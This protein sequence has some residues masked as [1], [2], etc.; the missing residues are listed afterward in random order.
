[1]H[2]VIRMTLVGSPDDP[3]SFQGGV[4]NTLR[5]LKLEP[6]RRA[7]AIVSIS[8]ALT[9]SC[10]SAGLD[11][12]AVIL[13]PN[14]VDLELFHPLNGSE[15]RNLRRA[16]GLNPDPRYIVFVGRCSFRKGIDILV[17]AFIQVARRH[18]DV[19]TLIIGPVD[20][21]HIIG[22]H[23]KRQNLLDNLKLELDRTGYS[24]RVHWVGTVENAHQYLQAA[25][26]F[27]LP[28]RRE[29]LPNAIVEAMAVGLPVVAARLEGITTDIIPSER[30]GML[31]NGHN[32]DDYAGALL[33][34]LSDPGRARSMGRLARA[35]AVSAFSL[36][37]AETRYAQLYRRLAGATVG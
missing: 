37:L 13:I 17:K 6:F 34:L 33:Q 36:D 7:D 30:E 27:C 20:D 12:N 23:S 21:S 8:S 35:R 26:I 24:S 19:E 10:R 32:P 5:I 1:M 28:T 14:G 9:N 3:S 11:P 16:L 29:G 25:D 2:P 15:K 4:R 22:H 31:I 18:S